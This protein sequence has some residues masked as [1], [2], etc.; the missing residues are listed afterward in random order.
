MFQSPQGKYSSS[1]TYAADKQFSSHNALH[2][3]RLAFRDL[4][5]QSHEARVL[6]GL[7]RCLFCGVTW[8][9]KILTSTARELELLYL[10]VFIPDS[11]HYK[12]VDL[13]KLGNFLSPTLDG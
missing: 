9:G 11:L 2:R 1:A 4:R 8:N 7:G 5:G 3:Q 10:F 12:V 13:Q 6:G